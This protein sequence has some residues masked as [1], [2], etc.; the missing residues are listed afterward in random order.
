MLGRDF[1]GQGW[2]FAVRLDPGG[3]LKLVGGEEKIRQSIQIILGTAPGERQMRPQFG[4]GVHDL[5]FQPNSSSLRTLLAEKVRTALV[6]WEPRID[7]VSVNAEVPVEGPN[8]LI[9]RIS[10]RI[11][12]NNAFHNMVYPFYLNEGIG[13]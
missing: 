5:V 3:H 8:Y 13:Q 11:R 9:V 10:Y 2:P 7:V 12:S 1:I 4:C 6:L